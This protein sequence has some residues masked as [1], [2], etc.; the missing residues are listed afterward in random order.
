MIR[1]RH[2]REKQGWSRAELARRSRINESNY[3]LIDRCRRIPYDPELLRIADALGWEGDPEALL[4]D[5]TV[6]A[7]E[8]IALIPERV[9][10]AMKNATRAQRAVLATLYLHANKDGEALVSGDDLDEDDAGET[11][12]DER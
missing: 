6:T 12:R 11:E 2:E 10:L 9:V 4:D 5:V 1:L 7:R 8:R 3:G